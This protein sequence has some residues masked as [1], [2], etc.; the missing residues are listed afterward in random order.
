MLA[1]TSQVFAGMPDLLLCP[2]VMGQVSGQGWQ[3]HRPGRKSAPGFASEAGGSPKLSS[4]LSI[5]WSHACSSTGS[6]LPA[7]ALQNCRQL[8]QDGPSSP[9][10][11]RAPPQPHIHPFLRERA[12]Q[13]LVLHPV[14]MYW[15][16]RQQAAP[17]SQLPRRAGNAQIP[18]FQD[19]PMPG[20]ISP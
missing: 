15:M 17:A 3:S 14:G 18:H 11:Q 1:N 12:S 13:Q 9:S 4:L 20:G 16:P 2:R 7:R 5:P 8:G 6:Q 19:V 10:C